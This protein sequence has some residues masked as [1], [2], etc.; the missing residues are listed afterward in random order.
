MFFG[1]TVTAA[2]AY[3]LFLTVKSRPVGATGWRYLIAVPFA[4]LVGVALLFAELVPIVGGTVC[5]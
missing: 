4:V 1:P 5:H 3:I 2:A